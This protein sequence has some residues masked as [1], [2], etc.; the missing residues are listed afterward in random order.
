[1]SNIAKIT[2]FQSVSTLLSRHSRTTQHLA[3]KASILIDYCYTLYD[4]YRIIWSM[5]LLRGEYSKKYLN[6]NIHIRK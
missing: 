6:N 4:V 3:Y 1:M 2:L 5:L